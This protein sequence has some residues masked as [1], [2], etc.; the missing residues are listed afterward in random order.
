[1]TQALLILT[2]SRWEFDKTEKLT[3]FD[4]S[5]FSIDITFETDVIRIPPFKCY[6]HYKMIISQNVLS[7][8]LVKIFFIS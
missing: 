2:L 4:G 8:A 5:L 1:M 3:N 7:V 6:L